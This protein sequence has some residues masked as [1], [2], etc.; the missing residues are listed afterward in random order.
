MTHLLASVLTPPQACG[1]R[2][3]RLHQNGQVLVLWDYVLLRWARLHHNPRLVTSP[4]GIT[5][6]KW[7]ATRFGFWCARNTGRPRFRDY[8]NDLVNSTEMVK[9]MGLSGSGILI[10]VMYIVLVA[11]PAS[12]PE[13]PFGG[14]WGNQLFWIYG[15]GDVRSIAVTISVY[16]GPFHPYHGVQGEAYPTLPH[17]AVPF[18]FRFY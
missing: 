5:S 12:Y 8:G 11:G 16:S 4:V 9:I 7:S 1:W 15:V 10:M 6:E 13:G 2:S 14:R 17:Q 3:C 18:F